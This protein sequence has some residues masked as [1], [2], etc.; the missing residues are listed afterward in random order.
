L[1]LR[2]TTIRVILLRNGKDGGVGGSRKKIIGGRV[3]ARHP[4]EITLREF[5]AKVWRD[6]GIEIELVSAAVVSGWILKRGVGFYPVPV[7]DPDDI[8]PPDVLR[9]LCLFYSVPPTDFHLDPQW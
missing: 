9:E 4:W 5:M 1:A 6:Y 8:L 3:L 2:T 7:T